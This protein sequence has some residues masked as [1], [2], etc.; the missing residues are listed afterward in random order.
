[1]EK[2][3]CFSADDSLN[4]TTEDDSDMK[5]FSEDTRNKNRR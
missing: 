1:M 5:D 4:L 3:V 2:E